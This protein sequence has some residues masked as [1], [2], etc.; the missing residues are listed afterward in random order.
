MARIK[1]MVRKLP[2]ATPQGQIGNKNILNRSERNIPFKVRKILPQ[3]KAVFVK[4]RTG[5]KT[6]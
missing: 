2:L 3:L 4:K 6:N 5:S 1:A